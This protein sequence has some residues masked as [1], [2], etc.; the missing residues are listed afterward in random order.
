MTKKKPNNLK[1]G[2]NRV[3]LTRAIRK[4]TKPKKG[5]QG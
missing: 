1:Q 5:R 3:G 2:R 4:P